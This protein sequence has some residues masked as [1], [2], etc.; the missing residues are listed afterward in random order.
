MRY[1]FIVA[2]SGLFGAVFAWKAFN[3]GKKI[4]VL[5]KRCIAGGN[6]TCENIAGINIHSYGPHIFHT[7]NKDIWELVQSFVPFNRYTN[8][9]VA[10][11][12]GELFNLPFNMNTFYKLWGTRTPQEAAQKIAAQR[13]ESGITNPKNLEEQAI[14]LA[15]RDIYE[16]LIKGYTEKQWGRKCNMLPASIIKRVPVRWTF[17]NNYYDDDYQ[18]IPRG[19]YNKLIEGLLN[20]IE[21]RLGEDFLNK[22]DEW[23]SKANCI[24]YTG[25]VDRY[26]KYCFGAL[27]YR[28]LRFETEILNCENYQGN[29]IINYT[30]AK[31]PYTRIIEHKHFEHKGLSSEFG[32]QNKTVITREYSAE[33]TEGAEPFYPINDETNNALY[34][35]YR[36]LS[37]NQSKVIFG[38]RLG[39]YRY[40]DMDDCI[41]SALKLSARIL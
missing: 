1:D 18:G 35:K 6:I 39:E 30:E 25:E 37:N 19:G 26:Y 12:K 41:E 34:Q 24:I 22:K 11:Y 13:R 5:E 7:N 14:F 8:S 10:N 16:K 9:P 29:A 17:D 20:G 40:Y 23:E 31:I 36:D 38:G 15:G 32:V 33:W 21:T 2:G 28:T 4:L 3:A 27:C